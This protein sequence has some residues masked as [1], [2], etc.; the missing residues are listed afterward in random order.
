MKTILLIDDDPFLGKVYETQLKSAG[1]KI[2]RALD[3]ES[4]LA[5]LQAETP[6]L[7]VL[8]MMLPHISGLEL[9]RRIRSSPD[10]R[11]IPVVVFSGSFAEET[12]Q[13]VREIGVNRILSKCQVVPREVIS[14]INEIM[15]GPG[16]SAAEANRTSDLKEKSSDTGD[17]LPFA[18]YLAACRRMVMEMGR[19]TDITSRL[20]TLEE[21]RS[22][23]GRLGSLAAAAGWMGQSSFCEA[24]EAFA[25][26]LYERSDRMTESALRTLVQSVDFLFEAFESRGGFQPLGGRKYQILVVDDDPIPRRAV[27]AA[28]RRIEQR[29]VECASG[30]DALERCKQQSFDLIFLDV[31]MPGKNGYELCEQLRELDTNRDTPVVFVTGHTDLQT[32]ARSTLSGGNDFIGKPFHIMELAVKT[33]LHLSRTR[34]S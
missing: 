30:G 5:A 31:D 15:F 23:V 20:Q 28:L 32:R 16:G 21:L 17:R 34:L 26:E 7:I 33:L 3:G 9:L 12:L 14:A 2:K 18:K 19:E 8:D 13:K 6:D 29:G 10:T 22:T 1:F 27:Q 25:G 11:E 24:L 4:G